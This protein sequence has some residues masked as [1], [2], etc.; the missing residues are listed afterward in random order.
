[1]INDSSATQEVA[2]SLV[3]APAA[4][5]ALVTPSGGLPQLQVTAASLTESYGAAWSPSVTVSGLQSG[6]SA[7]ASGTVFTYAGTGS[8]TYASSTTAPT[9]PGTYSITPSL[10]TLTITPASDAANY[11]ATVDFVSGTLV[12]TK[13]T[14]TSTSTVSHHLVFN[15][16]VRG[17]TLQ[18]AKSV[19][20]TGAT[21][22]IIGRSQL[23]LVIHIALTTP[24]RT[25]VHLAVVHFA[26][27]A[28][29]R[30]YV[31]VTH[32]GSFVVVR[33]SARP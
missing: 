13:P 23:R 15:A 5:V 6:D 19:T 17:L 10:S 7:S 14:I 4:A 29:T 20:V 12:V 21:A 30:F 18:N 3:A 25:G 27:G 11:D 32:Q 22:K 2:T 24:V 28:T 33:T 1:V 31:T 8:T 16:V 9:A 26:Q